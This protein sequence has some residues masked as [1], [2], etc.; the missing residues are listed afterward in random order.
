MARLSDFLTYS[1]TFHLVV[2]VYYS[3]VTLSEDE[4]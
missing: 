2:V 3:A 4:F 1:T